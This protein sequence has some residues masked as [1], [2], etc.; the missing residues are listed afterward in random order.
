MRLLVLLLVALSSAAIAQEGVRGE[1]PPEKPKETVALFLRFPVGR[2]FSYEWTDTTT[3]RRIY[4]DSS[5]LEYQRVLTYYLSLEAME[6]PRDGRTSVQVTIDSLRYSFSSGGNTL[7]YNPGDQMPLQFPDF[8]AAV[9][10]VNRQFQMT[11][12][13]YWDVAAVEG[14]MLD[15]LRSYVMEGAGNVSGFDSLQ[16][17]IWLRNISLPVLAH[18]ADPQKGALPN[19]RVAID[20]L[21]QKPF[22]ILAD[23][24]EL[25]DPRART[26]IVEQRG[27]V[28][29]LRTESD[30]LRPTLERVKL[31]NIQRFVEIIGGQGRCAHTVELHKAGFVEMATTDLAADVQC[32]VRNEIFTQQ[33]RSRY[34]WKLR[35]QFDY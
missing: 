27:P 24:I 35:G 34:V 7:R 33:I 32:R 19:G 16:Q 17:F 4:S 3:V 29:V 1:K 26:R 8:V 13:P 21:W 14:E 22:V 11:Y 5:T 2:L 15:W 30:S 12:S 10:P 31:Y 25:R 23:G 18:Y 9:V 20:S 28:F 6:S